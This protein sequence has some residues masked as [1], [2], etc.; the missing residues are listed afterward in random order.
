MF[1]SA[2]EVNARVNT[3]GLPRVQATQ[4][5]RSSS[6][7]REQH[8]LPQ[9]VIEELVN[10]ILILTDQRELIYAN[11]CARRILRLMN[12]GKPQANLVPNE[13]WHICQTLVE[14]R[15]LFSSQHWLIESKIFVD[16]SL[17]FHVGVKWLTEVMERPCLLV[18][19]QDQYQSIKNIANEEALNYGLTSREKE[20][21][22][23]H[24][25]NYTYKQISSELQIT[26]NT[27]KKHMKSIHVKRKSVLDVDE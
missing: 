16:G 18:S 14:S 7:S 13:I 1:V 5:E 20:I 19:I 11:N 22:L 23:L 26:P 3:S 15:K 25:A 10:G 8:L 9:E 12:R 4:N 27:V 2:S 21:W 6:P 24:R 17:T